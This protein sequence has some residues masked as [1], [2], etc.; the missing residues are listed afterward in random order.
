[1]T[2]VLVAELSLL[3]IVSIGTALIV[4]VWT[5]RMEERLHESV[6]SPGDFVPISQ[7]EV[8]SLQMVRDRERL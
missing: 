2:P 6:D 3:A 7:F 8:E 5:H 4:G 1:M